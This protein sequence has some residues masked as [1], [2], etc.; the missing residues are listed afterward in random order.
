MVIRTRGSRGALVVAVVGIVSALVLGA[1]GAA[2][3]AVSQPAANGSATTVPSQSIPPTTPSSAP[4]DPGTQSSGATSSTV[5]Y[6]PGYTTIDQLVQDSTFII[7]GTLEPAQV[8]KNYDGSL[9]TGYPITPEK[10]LGTIPPIGLSITRAEVSAADLRVGNDY[11]FFWAADTAAHTVCIVGGVRGVMSYDPASGTVTRLD[12]STNSQIPRTQSFEQ[13]SNSVEAAEI[14]R[15]RTFGN[16][17][18]VCA[19][20]ATG[21]PAS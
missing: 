10:V 4:S 9:G 5:P 16:Q 20:A 13:L 11:V 19:P 6:D 7:A 14:Q 21:L 15:S 18:P 3:T 2:P 1:C 17:P 8:G 12:H